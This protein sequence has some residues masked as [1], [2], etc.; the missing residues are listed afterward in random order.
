LRI[1]NGEDVNDIKIIHEEAIQEKKNRK[2]H[3]IE[4]ICNKIHNKLKEIS[5]KRT[6]SKIYNTLDMSIK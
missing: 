6:Q 3:R 2:I 1:K 5:K 4:N